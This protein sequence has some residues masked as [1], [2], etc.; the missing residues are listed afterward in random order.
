MGSPRIVS[1]DCAPILSPRTSQI[2]SSVPTVR[3]VACS[4]LL[5][6]SCPHTILQP[7]RSHQPGTQRC[8][9]DDA[10]NES[11]CMLFHICVTRQLPLRVPK[12]L[13]DHQTQRMS[14]SDPVTCFL[15]AHFICKDAYLVVDKA[16]PLT[17]FHL[18]R[19]STMLAPCSS[20]SFFD[21]HI[22]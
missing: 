17:E 8:G 15:D 7:R 3:Y 18:H 9:C 21:I 14:T 5:F 12:L 2:V 20:Y 19:F 10:V 4:S 1:K 13:E 11:C 6:D 16:N 22:W